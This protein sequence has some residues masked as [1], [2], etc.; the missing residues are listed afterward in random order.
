[1]DLHIAV[2]I[3]ILQEV[4]GFENRLI[5]MGGSRRRIRGSQQSDSWLFCVGPV[6]LVCRTG[7]SKCVG[8]STNIGHWGTGDLEVTIT[9]DT[10]YETR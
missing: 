2:H 9:D 7:G 10:T 5:E 3:L 4:P 1:M 8:I 6:A